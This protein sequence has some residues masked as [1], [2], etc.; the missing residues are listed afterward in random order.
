MDVISC[1][2]Y[3]LYLISAHLKSRTDCNSLFH[4]LK[5]LIQTIH[6]KQCLN[7]N[8]KKFF[9]VVLCSPILVKAYYLQ[10]M[11]CKH[12]HIEYKRGLPLQFTGIYSRRQK[13][14]HTSLNCRKIKSNK[15]RIDLKTG[16]KTGIH[17]NYFG[18][19]DKMIRL[20]LQFS[21]QFI[22]NNMKI[23]SCTGCF[24]MFLHI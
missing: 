3:S 4:S 17:Q 7:L 6:P 12:Q 22:A 23:K 20:L 14:V 16:N 11:A 5:N 8:L 24:Y 1:V 15:D 9:D 21:Q 10:Y 19:H 13:K 2:T 18:V